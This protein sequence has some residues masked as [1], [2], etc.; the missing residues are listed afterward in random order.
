MVGF[1]NTPNEPS[2]IAIDPGGQ[3]AYIITNRGSTSGVDNAGAIW[4]FKIDSGIGSLRPIA[5]T[6]YLTGDAPSN[7]IVDPSGK[8]VY[9]ANRQND[10]VSAFKIGAGGTLTPASGSPFK[11]IPEQGEGRWVGGVFQL[12]DIVA[13]GIK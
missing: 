13:A 7:A 9:V 3:F 2:A 12:V 5:A 10:S 8:S 11:V 4:G 6:P 1:P